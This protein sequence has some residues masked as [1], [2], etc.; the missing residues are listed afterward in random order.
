MSSDSWRRPGFT[1][2]GIAA[3]AARK[4][5]DLGTALPFHAREAAAAAG[6]RSGEKRREDVQRVREGNLGQR[7]T[8]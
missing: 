6:R 4:N 2:P 7:L 5:H 8:P 1:I 3:A